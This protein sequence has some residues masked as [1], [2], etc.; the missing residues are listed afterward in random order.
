[1]KNLIGIGIDVIE[2][3]VVE[4]MLHEMGE[5]FLK[6][7]LRDE[8]LERLP[9]APGQPMFVSRILA[10]KEAGMK[11]VGLGLGPSTTWR[12]FAMLDEPGRPGLRWVREEGAKVRFELGVSRSAK[13]VIATAWAF[14]EEE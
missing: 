4:R 9:D 10:S 3:R 2:V 12:S 1:M 7:A 6:L 13:T 8:E 14:R 5:R 11:A